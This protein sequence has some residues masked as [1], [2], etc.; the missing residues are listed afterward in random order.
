MA[1][2]TNQRAKS[3]VLTK[4]DEVH[5][6]MVPVLFPSAFLQIMALANLPLGLLE[7]KLCFLKPTK[8]DRTLVPLF[9]PPKKVL[10]KC[11]HY[12]RIMPQHRTRVAGT[13]ASI[14]L[15]D[16]VL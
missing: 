15:K 5:K 3:P 1:A 8:G 2:E 7:K 11:L 12:R 16:H 13:L 14:Y 6:D 4:N 9:A 10:R